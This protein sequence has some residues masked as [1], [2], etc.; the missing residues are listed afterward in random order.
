MRMRPLTTACMGALL[1]VSV[2]EADSF[3]FTTVAGSASSLPAS[4][5]GTN[6]SARF[7]GA[8]GA[9]LDGATNL[10]VTDA[11]TVRKVTPIVTN[12]VVTT[13]AGTIFHGHDDG[14]NSNAT[15]NSPYGVAVDA[16]GNL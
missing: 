13:L 3:T 7:Y 1:S 14:T 4:I 15:F 5:D 10:Y 16:A 6:S 8:T 9:A 12:W 11:N 2:A